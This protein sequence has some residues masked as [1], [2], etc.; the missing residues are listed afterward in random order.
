M[1][2]QSAETIKKLHMEN[3]LLSIKLETPSR[4]FQWEPLTADEQF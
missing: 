1:G 4:I 2:W 3:K